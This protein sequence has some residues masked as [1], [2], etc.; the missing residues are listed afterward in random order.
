[1]VGCENLYL[2]RNK[3]LKLGIIYS[4][5]S[6]YETD[7]IYDS[8]KLM[9]VNRLRVSRKDE[10]GNMKYGLIIADEGGYIVPSIFDRIEYYDGKNFIAKMDKKRYFIAENGDIIPS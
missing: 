1:M 4:G 8:A 6:R 3:A 2:K 7:C 9:A 5:D 10:D